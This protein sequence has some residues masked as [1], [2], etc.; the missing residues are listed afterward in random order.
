MWAKIPQR[1]I[2]K[3]PF[4]K[5]DARDHGGEYGKLP[6]PRLER[7]GKNSLKAPSAP[8][9]IQNLVEAAVDDGR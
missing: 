9:A 5:Q 8:G 7:D 1:P 6:S 2:L 4:Q 3:T